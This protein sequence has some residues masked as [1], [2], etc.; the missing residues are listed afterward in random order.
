MIKLR[1]LLAE[2]NF[3]TETRGAHHG[4]TD[5]TLYAEDEMGNYLG[6][7]DYSDYNGD[8][9]IQMVKVKPEARRQGIATALFKQLQIEYPDT[10]IQHGMT[11]GHGGDL[12]ASLPTT[13]HENAEYTRLTKRLKQ[14]QGAEQKLQAWFDTRQGP[15]SPKAAEMFNKISDEMWGIEQKLRHL[16]PGKTLINVK[17]ARKYDMEKVEDAAEYLIRVVWPTMPNDR[18]DRFNDYQFF[19]W[20]DNDQK[21]SNLFWELS[22]KFFP[23]D[24]HPE[25]KFKDVVEK[26][27]EELEH[28]HQE[29]LAK[30]INPLDPL[31]ILKKIVRGKTWEGAKQS[32]VKNTLGA[33]G[34]RGGRITDEEAE[35]AFNR[36]YK[37]AMGE[38][39]YQEKYFTD[40][41][42]GKLSDLRK[43]ELPGRAE[44]HI[45]QYSVNIFIDYFTGHTADRFPDQVKVYRGTNS[46]TAK[47]RPG[48]YVTFE[49]GYARTYMR[50]KFGSIIHDILPS[51]D[52]Y[53]YEV[54][55]DRPELVYWPEGHQIQRYEGNIPTFKE[56]WKEVNSW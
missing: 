18:E 25:D 28:K 51:K 52:L 5:L 47:V 16:K 31:F 42:Y 21:L 7:I 30:K 45:R 4:Q 13:Y 27:L 3:R 10:E 26:K 32:L 22:K 48:D 9:S 49:K 36:M 1:E 14:L 46:P 50:G 15:V 34:Y 8:P 24:E 41:G 53:V 43:V 29:R 2:V 37:N 54:D 6:H 39:V 19:L 40:R 55:L 12:V 23:N 33:W 20:L 38:T 17:E 56:F 35:T 11:V 44:D